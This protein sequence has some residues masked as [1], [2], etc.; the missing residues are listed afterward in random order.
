MAVPMVDAPPTLLAPNEPAAV[1]IYN[2]DGSSPLLLVAD[3]AGNLI[4][5]TLGTLGISDAERQ[6]HIAWDIGIAV[7][8]RS[9]ADALDAVLIR[10]NY[11]RL[12][13]DCNRPPRSPA[14]IPEV[15]E[16]TTIPGNI[17]LSNAAK[18]ARNREIFL[19]YHLAIEAEL[20]RRQKAARRTAL[21]ALHSFTPI[22]K[23]APRAMQVALLYNRDPRLARVLLEFLR[24][25]G[26]L[27]VADNEPYFVSDKTDYTIP[28]H[29]EKRK[30]PHVLI[31]IRQDLIVD[32]AGQQR[33]AALLK[34]L[35]PRAYEQIA[36]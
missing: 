15:S 22:F 7:V 13:I 30:L 26:E 3:H 32:L 23:S 36:T 20:D 9:L 11:S 5:R 29:G 35:L 27:V 18:A 28:V 21:I 12:V 14:S 6:R 10:Q 33:L 17:G 1:S 16:L 25:A 24:N 34:D 8:G 31:E 19:P 4:P 2:P